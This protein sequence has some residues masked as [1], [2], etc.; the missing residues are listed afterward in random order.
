V[1]A[2]GRN[3][4]ATKSAIVAMKPARSRPT[5]GTLLTH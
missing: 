1:A 4:L 5:M 2:S 3:A